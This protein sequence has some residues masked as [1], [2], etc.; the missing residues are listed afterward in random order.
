MNEMSPLGRV[1]YLEG[2][3]K[4]LMRATV[5]AERRRG[6]TWVQIGEEFGTGHSTVH[7]RF[8]GCVEHAIDPASAWQAIAELAAENAQETPE[9]PLG[10]EP[11][12]N[13]TEA[14]LAALLDAHGYDW[15][16]SFEE[17]RLIPTPLSKEAR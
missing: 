8:A 17:V 1:Q 4:A 9:V 5:A 3:V 10:F 2:M 13:T 7:Q 6:R 15:E 11:R 16:R 14:L 12:L